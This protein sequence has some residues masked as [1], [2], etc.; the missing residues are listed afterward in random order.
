MSKETFKTSGRGYDKKEV[1]SFLEVV[2]ENYTKLQ[3]AYAELCEKYRQ[4]SAELQSAKDDIALLQTEYER[5]IMD[6]NERVAALPQIDSVPTAK[7]EAVAR[8]LIDAEMTAI[9]II[10]KAEAEAERIKSEA[11][12]DADNVIAELDRIKRGIDSIVNNKV[13]LD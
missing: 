7:A 1:D 13:N 3:T 2:D 5:Q 10:G 12:Y 4:Q 6:L 8:A 9:N 11:K